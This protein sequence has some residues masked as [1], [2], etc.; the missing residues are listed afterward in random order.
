MNPIDVSFTMPAE[1]K[2]N[3]INAIFKFID[4]TFFVSCLLIEWQRLLGWIN[5][6]LNTFPLLK[7][8]LPKLLHEI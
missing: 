5:W 1:L 6:G 4:M 3:L 7:L 2:D 8:G